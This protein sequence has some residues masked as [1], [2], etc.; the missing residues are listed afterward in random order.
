MKVTV[1]IGSEATIYVPAAN[2][3]KVYESGKEVSKMP[4]IQ[5]MEKQEHYMLYKV[6]SGIY[7][8]EVV[9]QGRPTY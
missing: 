4:E 3:Q 5:F 7:E 8:F 6:G 2:E 9:N 1:P